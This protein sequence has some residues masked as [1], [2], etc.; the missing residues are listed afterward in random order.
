MSMHHKISPEAGY[1]HIGSTGKFSLTE[2]KKRFVEMLEAMAQHKVGKVLLDGRA[3]VGNPRLIERF[4]YG[5]FAAQTV[6]NFATRAGLPPTQFAYVLVVPM[7]DPGKFGET[8]AVNRGMNMKVFDNP[9]DAL[10]WLGM[11]PADK[12]SADGG[13]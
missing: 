9:D 10:G 2:A 8:V 11:A 7:R 6:L 3:L 13:S 5:E 4:Y 12:P 1:L